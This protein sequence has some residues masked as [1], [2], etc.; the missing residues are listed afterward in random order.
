[1]T[2]RSSRGRPPNSPTCWRDWR[3]AA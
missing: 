3:P 1:V 2:P